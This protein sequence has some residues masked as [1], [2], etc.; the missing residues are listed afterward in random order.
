MDG[1][2]GGDEDTR[3]APCVGTLEVTDAQKSSSATRRRDGELE[4]HAPGRH[5]DPGRYALT[6]RDR[7]RLNSNNDPLSTPPTRTGPGLGHGR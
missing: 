3:L 1:P 6:V 4:R 2:A 5:S 7:T